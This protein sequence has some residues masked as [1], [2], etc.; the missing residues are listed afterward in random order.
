LP[1]HVGALNR[2]D[3]SPAPARAGAVLR[4]PVVRRT[5]MRAWSCPGMPGPY[6]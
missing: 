4:L 5:M 1:I 2:T 3:K 6:D